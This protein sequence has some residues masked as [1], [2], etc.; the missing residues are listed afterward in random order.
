MNA[1]KVTLSQLTV[2]GALNRSNCEFCVTMQ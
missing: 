2:A 1:I